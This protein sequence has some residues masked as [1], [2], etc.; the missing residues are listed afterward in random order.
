MKYWN[1][2][3]TE[4]DMA[5]AC[6]DAADLLEGHW[7]TGE[8]YHEWWVDNAGNH[9]DWNDGTVELTEQWAYC[10]E[11]AMAAAIG[12]D[13]TDLD[14]DSE[15]RSNLLRCPVYK[16]VC[17]TLNLQQETEGVDIRYGVGDLPNWNDNGALGSE[18]KAL[19]L[20]RATAKRLRGVEA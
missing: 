10:I 8:W 14:C 17:D 5:E 13:A 19:D 18:Q 7:T 11:G 2:I 12:L 1:T 15:E 6:E 9:Y 3:T 16:A 20:L 4:E